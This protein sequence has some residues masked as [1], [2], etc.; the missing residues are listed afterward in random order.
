MKGKP[1]VR[2]GERLQ[3]QA[4]DAQAEAE[5]RALAAKMEA[6]PVEQIGHYLDQAAML[7]QWIADLRQL[8]HG[9]LEENQKV[10]GW[11]LVNK[12]AIRKWTDEGDAAE[13]LSEQGVD[14]FEK[15]VVSPAAAEKLLKKDKIE[16]PAA[17]VVA[18][19]SGSTLAP[20]SDPRPA[21]E[22]TGAALVKALAKLQ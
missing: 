20:E 18:V 16:L 10:P 21:I 19:S 4:A 11:K 17:L 7:E 6:L 2:V 14:P 8:A 22:Q 9:L 13:W 15:N 12:R 1:H 3:K 5:F